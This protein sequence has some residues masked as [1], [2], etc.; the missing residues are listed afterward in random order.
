MSFKNV[1]EIDTESAI[2][3]ASKDLGKLNEL[4]REREK[5]YEETKN[6]LK[7]WIINGSIELTRLGSFGLFSPSKQSEQPF[8]EVL[9]Y[10]EEN[11]KKYSGIFTGGGTRSELPRA[12]S[13][14]KTCGKQFTIKDIYDHNFHYWG[15]AFV[16]ANECGKIFES[17][18]SKT[19]IAENILL[20]A[21]RTIKDVKG[22]SI[23]E[24]NPKKKIFLT[25]S[26]NAYG[27]KIKCVMTEH[28]QG[29]TITY[30]QYGKERRKG[31]IYST[32]WFCS[33]C[34]KDIEEA[35][36]KWKESLEI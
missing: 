2:L 18:R 24:G 1:W 16:H 10:N 31:K 13:I 11:M 25:V 3:E 26:F 29:I 28:A 36:L 14:C 33:C 19:D 30:E 15:N 35:F 23:K 27:Y 4:I 7:A 12:L 8:P 21:N 22:F 34:Y 17:I 6:P 20:I 9:E 32:E 5:Y